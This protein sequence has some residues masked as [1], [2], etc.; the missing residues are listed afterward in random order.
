MKIFYNVFTLVLFLILS[1]GLYGHC[2][3]PCGIYDDA[4]R[5]VQIEEDIATIRKAMSMIKGLSGKSDAQ[6]INQMIRWVNTKE[7]HADKIQETVSSYFLAQRIKPKKKGAAGRQKYVNQTLLLQ[8]LIVA[9]MKCKQNV[10]QSRCEAASDLV[11]EF[12]VSYFDEHGMEHLKQVQ[13][14]K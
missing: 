6:S 11:V 1:G 2:Q 8:Q 7:S 14:K 3:V 10:D 4:V 5:I 12:S 13:N 9:A